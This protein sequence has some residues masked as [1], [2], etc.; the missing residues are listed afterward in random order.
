M[1][2][3]AAHRPSR[4]AIDANPIWRLLDDAGIDWCASRA[5]LTAQHGRRFD[6]TY[7]ESLTP[8]PSA[9]AVFAGM[10][11]PLAMHDLTG[12]SQTL[13]P[14][15]FSGLYFESGGTP[16]PEPGFFARLLQPSA[17]PVPLYDALVVEVFD[18]AVARFTPHLGPGDDGSASN[19]IGRQWTSGPASIRLVAWP[20]ELNA[21]PGANRYHEREPRMAYATH[22]IVT[23]G[24]ALSASADELHWLSRATP[25]AA[26]PVA[27]IAWNVDQAPGAAATWH[28]EFTRRIPRSATDVQRLAL[29]QHIDTVCMSQGGDLLLLPAADRL[30]VIPMWQVEAV[31][32]ERCLPAKGSGYALVGVRCRTDFGHGECRTIALWSAP[33][34][35]DLTE[36]GAAFAAMVQRP[37]TVGPYFHND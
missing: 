27:D 7:Q 34:A 21:D 12:A 19:T 33:N 1:I 17:A 29:S 10:L 4:H 28:T 30:G 14:A 26:P 36:W 37:C 11:K 22:V 13:P 6:R 15:D 32:V 25:V 31:Q 8:L 5:A 18:R 20:R 24:F 23:T 16:A 2:D 9:H 3:L 35:D